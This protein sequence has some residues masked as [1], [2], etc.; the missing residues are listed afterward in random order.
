MREFN[1]AFKL[2]K[3]FDCQ[4]MSDKIRDYFWN[5]FTDNVSNDCYIAFDVELMCND[6]R[7]DPD[8]LEYINSNNEVVDWL[9]ENGAEFG[10]EVLIKHWW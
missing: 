4:D 9:I 5:V 6:E 7:A 1:M 3:V 2:R 10:E 8:M